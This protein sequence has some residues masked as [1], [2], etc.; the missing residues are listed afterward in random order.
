VGA[1]NRNSR[2]LNT[3]FKIG[4]LGSVNSVGEKEW[5]TF[6]QSAY[7]S[8]IKAFCLNAI[9]EQATTE[10]QSFEEALEN[11]LPRYMKSALQKPAFPDGNVMM[12]DPDLQLFMNQL[13]TSKSE[14]LADL[15]NI[16]VEEKIRESNAKAQEA[17][18]TK[19]A[20]HQR[21]PASER[22]Y[23]RQSS[24]T[25]ATQQA[26]SADLRSDI[27]NF[28]G[29]LGTVGQTLGKEVDTALKSDE[30]A[31]LKQQAKAGA[32]RFLHKIAD[33]L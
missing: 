29:V 19:A 21:Q 27:G 30:A 31:A 7:A 16:A 9:Q 32:K 20:Q 28:L 11:P 4:P 17:A 2:L 3:Y 8:T 10:K 15:K 13:N 24:Q 23:V 5:D 25:R 6:T 14:L 26:K 1:E 33:S 12:N 22:N 18:R